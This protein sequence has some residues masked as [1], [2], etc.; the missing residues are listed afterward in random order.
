MITAATGPMRRRRR[1]G[2]RG[3]VVGGTVEVDGLGAEVPARGP[4]LPLVEEDDA[5]DMN[6]LHALSLFQL[7]LERCAL[8]PGR[9]PSVGGV[10]PLA[11][12]YA[13][14]S[15]LGFTVYKYSRSVSLRPFASGEDDEAPGVRS[16]ALWELPSGD[17]A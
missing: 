9:P 11:S 3:P 12:P 4:E 6:L 5:S 1:W 10:D 8:A 17:V 16:N 14:H 15:R 13:E 7:W 2:P